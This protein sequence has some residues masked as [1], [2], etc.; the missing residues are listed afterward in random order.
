MNIGSRIRKIR[1][2]QKRTL[3]DIAT[4]CK[5][6]KSLLS[7]IENGVVTPPIATL[8]K[9]ADALGAKMSTLVEEGKSSM[10]IFTS[11]EVVKNANFLKTEMGYSFFP[12]AADFVDKQIQPFLFVGYKGEVIQHSLSHDGQE[13]VYVLEGEMEFIVGNVIHTLK[14]GDTLYFDANE[15][16]GIKPISNK[17]VYLNIFTV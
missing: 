10:S 8:S 11:N 1:R 16:H 17:V 9:I 7:K 2:Q 14:Q 12:F 13:F 15:N 5:L 3:N 4:Q 6:S